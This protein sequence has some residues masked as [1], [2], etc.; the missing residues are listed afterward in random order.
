MIHLGLKWIRNY[1]IC[2]Q[3][4]IF[5][6]I[7]IRWV[8]YFTN[9]SVKSP[10]KL[11][12]YMHNNKI[13]KQWEWVDNFKRLHLRV[14]IHILMKITLQFHSNLAPMRLK[15]R[16]VLVARIH[17]FFITYRFSLVLLNVF[18]CSAVFSHLCL[19]ASADFIRFLR[20][21]KR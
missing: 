12:A 13:F 20:A 16:I 21:D 3:M 17:C 4:T 14:N 2:D 8:K 19:S 18:C 5:Y 15:A 1:M 11:G 10:L 6:A 9:F 7:G